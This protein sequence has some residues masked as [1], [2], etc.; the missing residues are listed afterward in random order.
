ME[1]QNGNVPIAL[2]KRPIDRSDAEILI[3]EILARTKELRFI[4]SPSLRHSVQL[5]MSQ[6]PKQW[7]RGPYV[8][9]HD[10]VNM[11]FLLSTDIN[12]DVCAV[13]TKL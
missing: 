10:S 6:R 7:R 2:A 9:S 13:V 12:P 4:C 8:L 5:R 1:L 11:I 3:D